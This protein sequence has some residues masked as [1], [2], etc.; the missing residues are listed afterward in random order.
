MKLTIFGQQRQ[1]ISDNVFT[2]FKF[3]SIL[4]FSIVELFGA[5]L[6]GN[7]YLCAV[8]Y[9]PRLWFSLVIIF[10]EQRQVTFHDLIDGKS[11]RLCI[12]E[13]DMC[14]IVVLHV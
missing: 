1:E 13:L 7:R 4:R 8:K 12:S 3:L 6:L 10:Q 2:A 14:C 5:Q 9:A 11:V